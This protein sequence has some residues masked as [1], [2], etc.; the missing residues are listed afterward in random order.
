MGRL[1]DIPD[2]GLPNHIS[3]AT[4]GFDRASPAPGEHNQQEYR[5]QLGY[6]AERLAE[7]HAGGVI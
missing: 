3:N 2:T 1:E 6:S 4:V 7:L 5:E